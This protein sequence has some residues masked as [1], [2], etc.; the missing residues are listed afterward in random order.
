MNVTVNFRLNLYGMVTS[1]SFYKQTSRQRMVPSRKRR[2]E[3]MS[4]TN[5]RSMVISE[6]AVS[7]WTEV[8]HV[9]EGSTLIG[10][11]VQNERNYV[12]TLDVLSLTMVRE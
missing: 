9:K 11:R 8:S 2:D 10:W 7:Y 1:S 5:E 4:K 6:T 12:V 3:G